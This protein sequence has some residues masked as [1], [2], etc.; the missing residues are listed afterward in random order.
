MNPN[1]SS[2]EKL[3]DTYVADIKISNGWLYYSDYNNSS[4]NRV[5]LDGTD[6][7]RLTSVDE[8]VYANRGTFYVFGDWIEYRSDS[9]DPKNFGHFISNANAP[10]H[11]RI[12]L[13]NSTRILDVTGDGIYIQR[14]NILYKK[15]I[16]TGDEPPLSELGV[17]IDLTK[18][19]GYVHSYHFAD[20]YLL[21]ISKD[22]NLKKL[23]FA[24][25]TNRTRE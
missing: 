21:Y 20:G 13:E 1:G 23:T 14:N 5:R 15:D 12:K 24:K 10:E 4:I 18:I 8:K 9:D 6:N 7:Q 22:N 11:T 16:K 19:D 17:D 2:K 3:I 25:P